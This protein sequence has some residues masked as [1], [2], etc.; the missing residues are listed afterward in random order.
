MSYGPVIFQLT[1][2]IGV[3][4]A[5]VNGIPGAGATGQLSALSE[6]AVNTG[7]DGDVGAGLVVVVVVVVVVVAF[8]V[9]AAGG[10]GGG[11]AVGGS[12]GARVPETA[13]AT[14]VSATV[15]TTVVSGAD[16][17]AGTVVLGAVVGTTVEDG[18]A[19]DVAASV[20][21]ALS[22]ARD[23]ELLPQAVIN[24]MEPTSTVARIL[25]ISLTSASVERVCHRKIPGPVSRHAAGPVRA[26]FKNRTGSLRWRDR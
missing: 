21:P 2:T 19:V 18:A 3:E 25:F 20:T 1:V 10:G 12:T 22:V 11:A 14:V 13:G 23:S 26:R 7:P 16:V 5:R 4:G 6:N 15:T 9:V 17:V 24:P 8:V